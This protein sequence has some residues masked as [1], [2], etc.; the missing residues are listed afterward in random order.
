MPLGAA[1]GG[2]L[3]PEEL[4]RDYTRAGS[5]VWYLDHGSREIIRAAHCN[6]V[7]VRWVVRDWGVPLAGRDPATLV[8][9]IPVDALRREIWQAMLAGGEAVRANP[10]Q[11]DN[12]F[13]QGYLV[14]NYCRMTHDLLCGVPGSK[15][16]GAE[17]AKANLDPAWADLIDRAWD[18]RPDPANRGQTSPIPPTFR[19][20]CASCA[21]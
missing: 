12:R 18:G 9:P 4:L 1:S 20:C 14:L 8:D 10:A 16:A 3:L 6:T 21:S 11:Y 7:L 13:Y 19:R 2:V 15:R 5:P 17:W